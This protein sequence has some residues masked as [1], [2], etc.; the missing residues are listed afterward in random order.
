MIIDTLLLLALPASGKSELRRYLA[1]LPTEVARDDFHLGTTIQVDD[2]PYVHLMRRISGEQRR[3]GTRPAFFAGDEEP[4][5]DPR[6]WLTLIH[7][8]AEDV[9]GLGSIEEHPTAPEAL[10]DRFAA[11]RGRA[12]I[13]DAVIEG[14]AALAAAIAGDAAALAGGLS[15]IDRDRL[16]GST[17]VIEFARGGPDGAVPPLPDPLGYHA[18]LPALG[19]PILERASILWV[20]TDPAESRRRNRERA[21]PGPDGAASILHH[22]VPEAVMAHDY[23]MDDLAWL[24]ESSPVSGT[25][26]VEAGDETCLLPIARF[27]NRVD[28][29]SFLRDEPERWPADT[30]ALL[31]HDLKAAFDTLTAAEPEG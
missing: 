30:L 18:S 12:G 25:I 26:A 8:V 17:I 24:V 11:A 29:T 15:V 9:A 4:F 16:G 6:D 14:G 3:I 31:H 19:S 7:L 27:D 13:P 22:G 5:R 1:H 21:H 28:H 10:L 23:G 2:Y 20:V